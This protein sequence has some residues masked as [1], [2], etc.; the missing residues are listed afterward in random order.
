MCL[1]GKDF[2]IQQ[3]GVILIGIVMQDNIFSTL[4]STLIG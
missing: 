1:G 3:I 2:I 4:Q